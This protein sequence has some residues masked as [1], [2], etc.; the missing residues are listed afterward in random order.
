MQKVRLSRWSLLLGVSL[1]VLGTLGLQQ[2]GNEAQA[3]KDKAGPLERKDFHDTLDAVLDR[4][5]EPVDTPTVMSRGLKYMVAGLDPYS[6]YMTAKER[7]LATARARQGGSAGLVT[8]LRNAGS[9]AAAELEAHIGDLH[10][11]D[12]ITVLLAE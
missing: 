5:V 6:N 9:T 7:E 1:G 12:L 4:Y 8:T 3:G 10:R 2:I 11:A